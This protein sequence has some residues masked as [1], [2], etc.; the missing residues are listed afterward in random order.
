M[1]NLYLIRHGQASF[2]TEDYDRLSSLGGE[3]SR[4]A[5][6]WFK[7]CGI[8]IHHAVAGGLKRHIQT[9]NAFFA[10]YDG[11][12]ATRTIAR[13][14]NFNEVDQL[15]LL[16]PFHARSEKPLRDGTASKSFEEF[17][18]FY[19]PAFFRW[20]SGKFDHEYRQPFPDFDACC[21]TA[22]LGAIGLAALDETVVAFTSGGTIGLIC[23]QVLGLSDKATSELMWLI[24]NTSV[25]L[26]AWERER[27]VL[28][29]F[30]SLAH[31]QLHGDKNLITL[32]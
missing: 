12:G 2:G 14:P 24:S 4:L 3:Q 10:G 19:E 17:R 32:S 8:E 1:R 6:E 31:L 22:L 7:R 5:G 9:A 25:S 16:N 23:R 20:T 26:L 18:R 30:N 21:S 13:D 27:F 28:K 29:L 11:H 15:D